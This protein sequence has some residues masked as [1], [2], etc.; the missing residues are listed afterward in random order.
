MLKKILWAGNI[1]PIEGSRSRVPK[2]GGGG[3]GDTLL[4]VASQEWYGTD[5]CWGCA[6]LKNVFVARAS[7]RKKKDFIKIL[8]K[9]SCWLIFLK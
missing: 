7:L 8:I 2:R 3:L 1:A 4:S 5:L 6:V 9:D